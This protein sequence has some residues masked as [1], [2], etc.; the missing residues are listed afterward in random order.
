MP[1]E[2]SPEDITVLT[3]IAN[4][5]GTEQAIEWLIDNDCLVEQAW[6]SAAQ[7]Q[8][9]RQWAVTVSTA[10]AHAKGLLSSI[11]LSLPDVL[12]DEQ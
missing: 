5:V 7:K 2:Y 12:P 6:L 4:S 3:E 11:S 1:D 10:Y 9:E 8:L